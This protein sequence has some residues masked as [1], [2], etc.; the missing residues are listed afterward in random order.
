MAAKAKDDSELAV[1]H[2][3]KKRAISIRKDLEALLDHIRDLE[4]R[5]KMSETGSRRR[6]VKQ[7]QA[8]AGSAAPA[9]RP[10]K[11]PRKKKEEPPMPP[12]V[13]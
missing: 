8:A 6:A 9:Q 7:Q 11:K 2:L 13:R 4:V 5:V 10:K 12:K 1:L 3:V